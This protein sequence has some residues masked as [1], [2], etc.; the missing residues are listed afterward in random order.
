MAYVGTAN[1]KAIRRL[2]HLAVSD[3]SDD[4]RR[5]AVTAIGFVLCNAHQQVPRIVSLLS[6]SFNPHVRYGAA[7]AVGIS[8]AGTG[9]PDALNLLF[10]LTKDRVD[11]VRQGA[12]IA[13]AMVLIQHNTYQEP[14]VGELRKIITDTVENKH[15]DTMTKLGAILAAGILDA[16][17]RNV[18]IALRSP[19]GHKKMASIVGMALFLQFWYWYPLTH[20]ISLSFTPTAVIGLNKDL[21]MPKNFA[22]VSNA[23]PSIFAY[24]PPTEIKKEVKTKKLPT[25]TLSVTAKAKA[26]AKKKEEEKKAE[27]GMDVEVDA[28]DVDSKEAKKEEVEEKPMTEEEKKA[29][30]EKAAAE[31]L[32]AEPPSEVLQN[33]ARVTW[34]QQKVLSFESEQ[35]YVPIKKQLAGIVMLRDSHPEEAEELV[36]QVT[37]KSFGPDEEEEASPPEPF[38]FLR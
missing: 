1:N 22:F 31:K 3:V 35:R 25:A 30:E 23:K 12:L 7:L 5:A 18:T 28:M 37:P 10:P 32:A 14:R 17:G 19:S 4:V 8:C 21:Q 29:A 6:E 24:P 16:G 33:P 20:F 34:A 27:A 2:L 36:S 9:L 13:L 26:K 11:Y 38:E 15:G